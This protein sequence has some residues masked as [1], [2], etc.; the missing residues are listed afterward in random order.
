MPASTIV[1]CFCAHAVK[2][3]IGCAGER[4]EFEL[5]RLKCAFSKESEPC[6]RVGMKK[7]S[8]VHLAKEMRHIG[9]VRCGYLV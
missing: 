4:A 2:E 9:T 6:K 1:S 3:G 5:R 8:A 7:D